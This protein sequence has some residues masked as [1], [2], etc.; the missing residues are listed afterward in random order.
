MHIDT[1]CAR[2]DNIKYIA[3]H[4]CVLKTNCKDSHLSSIISVFHC[5]RCDLIIINSDDA[6]AHLNYMTNN[7]K[8]KIEQYNLDI[9]KLKEK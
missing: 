5:P 7:N 1:E 8:C 6:K 9:N 4:F 2:S 3:K